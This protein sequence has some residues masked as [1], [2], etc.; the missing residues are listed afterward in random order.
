MRMP[1]PASIAISFAARVTPSG[2]SDMDRTFLAKPAATTPASKPFELQ[3][4]VYSE[5]SGDTPCA[6]LAPM[7]YEP[8]YAYP[9]IVWLHG[10]GTEE[11]QLL[12]VMPLVSMRNYV[13]VAPRGTFCEDGDRPARGYQWQQ[14][15]QHIVLA[16][17]RVFESMET[18]C[19]KYHIDERRVFLAGSDS[20]GTMALR[21]ALA[22]PYCFRGVIS[23]GGPLPAGR[24]PFGSL[25]EARR[26]PVLVA[27]GQRSTACPPELLCD[28]LR[29]LHTA[30]MAVTFRQYP[31]DQTLSPQMLA[32]VDR[33]MIEQITSPRPDRACSDAD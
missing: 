24:T 32:D 33:W 25:A 3:S 10:S 31:G 12:R 17:H 8:G 23:L 7:H 11:R 9:L 5:A 4:G 27:A 26:L 2:L 18:A 22:H 16:E 29:L 13:A 21:I 19:S 6:L 20:G 28:S 1:G 30:G 15:E 14:T